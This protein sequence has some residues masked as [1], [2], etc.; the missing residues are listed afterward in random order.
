[1]PLW[2]LWNLLCR[3]DSASRC[4]GPRC[5]GRGPPWQVPPGPGCPQGCFSSLPQGLAP[6]PTWEP[7]APKFSPRRLVTGCGGRPAQQAG[8]WGLQA[9][10]P[11]LSVSSLTVPGFLSL[12][13]SW[14]QSGRE[15]V[16]P[17]G[18]TGRT[19]SVHP[20]A[21]GPCEDLTPQRETVAQG[22][23]GAGTDRAQTR[24]GR[25]VLWPPLARATSRDGKRGG[26]RRSLL[27]AG[28]GV[29]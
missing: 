12:E 8:F 23:P 9:L 27:D 18:W 11:S 5:R 16:L 22:C 7:A 28:H 2:P 20:E 19:L 24:R 3:G 4:T 21:S 25:T 6:A 14:T 26:P 1:M 15:A 13:E 10:P 17:G 29:G